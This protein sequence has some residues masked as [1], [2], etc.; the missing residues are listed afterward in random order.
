M[1]QL[2]HYPVY[3]GEGANGFKIQQHLHHKLTKV[4]VGIRSSVKNTSKSSHQIVKVEMSHTSAP[5]GRSKVKS[6][7]VYLVPSLNAPVLSPL[8]NK[9]A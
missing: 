4:D 8:E 9:Q 6:C 1:D 7:P 5:A 3:V 2:H